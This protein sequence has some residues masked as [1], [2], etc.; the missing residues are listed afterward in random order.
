MAD[1]PAALSDLAVGELFHANGDNGASLICLVAAVTDTVIEARTVTTQ[2]CLDFDRQ[3]GIGKWGNGM[4]VVDSIAPLPTEIRDTLLGLDRRYAL[5][6]DPRL[7]DI[8]KRAL[9]F[10][11]SF[12]RANPI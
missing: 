9:I 10:V 5:G 1:R 6:G 11:S 7:L 12:Y 4:C 3:T 8:E 2:I